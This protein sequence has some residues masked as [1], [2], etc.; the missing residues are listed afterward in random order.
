MKR[1]ILAASLFTLSL[2][3][4]GTIDYITNGGFETGSTSGWSM[5]AASSGNVTGS[6]NLAFGALAVASGCLSGTNPTAGTYAAYSSTSF[7][8]INNS[9][10]KWTD[11]IS[12]NFFIPTGITISNATLS[13]IY[14]I[15]GSGTGA[16]RGV[17]V[18]VRVLAGSTVLA[19]Q[20]LLQNPSNS[21]TV[22]WTADS[23]NMT[24][25]LAAHEGQTLTLQFSSSAL[26][27][28]SS[29]PVSRSTALI[30]GFDNI[31]LNVTQPVPEPPA[32]LL[33]AS[34]LGL[35]LL[36]RNRSRSDRSRL[37]ELTGACET[38]Q[39]RAQRLVQ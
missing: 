37:C 4:G 3:Y 29:A 15:T 27:V 14:T 5:S 33:M 13:F 26:Y 32:V 11:T 35:G 8:S 6:C 21:G 23:F 19:S 22:P 9:T 2:A 17:T 38:R 16:F 36:S 1:I 7:P 34:A 20:T 24:S 25:I 28:T 18:Q 10:G 39:P 12:Q 31:H 30:T